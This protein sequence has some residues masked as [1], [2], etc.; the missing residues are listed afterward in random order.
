MK[1]PLQ[2]IEGLFI[3]SSQIIELMQTL[4]LCPGGTRQYGGRQNIG[5]PRDI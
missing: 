1:G 4:S 2:E 3:G 5:T